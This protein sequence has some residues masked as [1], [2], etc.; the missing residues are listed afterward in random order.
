MTSVVRLFDITKYLRKNAKEFDNRMGIWRPINT[1]NEF[2]RRPEVSFGLGIYKKKH[3]ND[4]LLGQIG[5]H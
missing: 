2:S 4:N 3:E 5:I 1:T